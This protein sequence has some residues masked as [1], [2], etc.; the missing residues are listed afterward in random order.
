MSE[1]PTPYPLDGV[2]DLHVFSPR[3]AVDVTKEYIRACQSE[4]VLSIRVIHGKGRGVLRDR[5]Q[6][7]LDGHP[8]VASWQTAPDRSGWGATLVNLNPVD[9]RN[10][11]AD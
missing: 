4:G 2:L 8:A 1:S 9:E 6:R 3:D 5:I 7:L 11:S 10:G